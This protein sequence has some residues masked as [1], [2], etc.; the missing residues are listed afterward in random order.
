MASRKIFT[1]V[2]G[3]RVGRDRELV[4]A[5]AVDVAGGDVGAGGEAGDLLV[6][7]ADLAARGQLV[8]PH[9]IRLARGDDELVVE[10][11]VEVAGRDAERRPASTPTS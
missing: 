6:E 9:G 3:A 10:V 2:F 1:F 7:R 11:A 5:V 4:A 8:D